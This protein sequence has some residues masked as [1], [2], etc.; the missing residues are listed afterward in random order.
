MQTVKIRGDFKINKNLYMIIWEIPIKIP[1]E[2]DNFINFSAYFIK[3]NNE[4]ILKIDFDN[5]TYEMIKNNEIFKYQVLRLNKNN[6]K[7]W[8]EENKKDFDNKNFNM[9]SEEEIKNFKKKKFIKF[10]SFLPCSKGFDF[11]R[12]FKENNFY[13]EDRRKIDIRILGIDEIIK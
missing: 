3:E 11:K 5:G 2:I 4:I 12:L 1:L 8:Y 9:Y 10:S 13:L 7:S 6:I